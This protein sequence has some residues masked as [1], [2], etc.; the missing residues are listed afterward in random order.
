MSR[1][2]H[3]IKTVVNGRTF[4]SKAEARRYEE[5]LALERAHVISDLEPQP[6]FLL[7]DGF[8]KCP[9]CGCM[10][11]K[12]KKCPKCGTMTRTFRPRYYIADFQYFDKKSGKTKIED[13]KGSKGFMT[14]LFRFKW[15]LFEAK[16]PDK[17]LEIVTVKAEPKRPKRAAAQVAISEARR[18][19]A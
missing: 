2:Y 17:T 11:E 8:K 16:Y 19:K 4:D 3:N 1:K 10:P 12:G 7:Q 5:L 15:T 13:V 18:V 6:K 9:E 14:D